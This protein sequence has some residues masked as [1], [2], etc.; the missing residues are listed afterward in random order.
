MSLTLEQLKP[1]DVLNT[2]S[3][4]KWWQ[5]WLQ[6]VYWQIRH[7]QKRKWGDRA[8]TRDVH[9]RLYLGNGKFMSTEPPKTCIVDASE[10]LGKTDTLY[11]VC[12]YKDVDWDFPPEDMARMRGF[13]QARLLGTAYDYGQLL[14]ILLKQLFPFFNIERLSIFDFG[15]KK[16]VCSVAVHAVL[17]HWWKTLGMA[18]E[19]NLMEPTLWPTVMNRVA[20]RTE[21]PRPLDEQYIEVACPADFANHDTFTVVYED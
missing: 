14:D 7:Y 18:P 16:K 8:R 13:I 9:S 5:F 10:V 15:R 2:S 1:G 6:V 17:L 19:C 21:R 11:R 20:I 3:T 12:R 4:P